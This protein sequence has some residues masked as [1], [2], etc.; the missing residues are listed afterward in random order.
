MAAA[1]KTF[2]SYVG[3]TDIFT[4]IN[5]LNANSTSTT[6]FSDPF[7][8]QKIQNAVGYQ[9]NLDKFNINI[10]S[11]PV[12]NGQR[13]TAP[14]FLN[15]IRLNINSFLNTGIASFQPY[16]DP[17]DQIND[18]QRWNSTNPL[19]SILTLDIKSD[20]GSVIVSDFAPNYWT[21][22]TIRTPIDGAHPVSG[23]R[24]WGFES[25]SNGTLN[26]YIKGADRLTTGRHEIFQYVTGIPF[27][28][29]DQLWESYQQKVSAFVNLNG[30]KAV[31]GGT[32]KE[33]PNYDM[34][35]AY[36]D[37]TITLE[38]L[39]AAKGCQ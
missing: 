30:G 29:A 2:A 34:L 7:F 10:E 14:Q 17:S 19:G 37:G 20:H 16:V 28:Q 15:Y 8:V 36:F 1:F 31:V 24:Q 3:P 32:L 21:V 6:L 22:S 11:L 5:A 35:K 27:A 33:R 25:L 38:Q 4:R 18:Q 9:I 13:L 23:N 12:V 39:K 26:F